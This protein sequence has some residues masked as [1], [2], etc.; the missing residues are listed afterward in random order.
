MTEIISPA[1]FE[2]INISA[3]TLFLIS[4]TEAL[5]LVISVLV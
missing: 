5:I 4:V 2:T 1:L 3:G